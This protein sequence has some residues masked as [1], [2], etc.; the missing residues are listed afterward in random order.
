MIY[1][2]TRILTLHSLTR[3]KNYAKI[4]NANA[5]EKM[6]LADHE[7]TEKTRYK[8]YE[9]ICFFETVLGSFNQCNFKMFVVG[10]SWW[11]TFLLSL[12]P[13]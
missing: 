8:K 4:T 7:L 5:W 10:Q 11:S 9:N 3:K 13:K 1:L 6:H 2:N 12:P